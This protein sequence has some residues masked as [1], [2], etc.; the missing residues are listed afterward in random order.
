MKYS[1]HGEIV[2]NNTRLSGKYRRKIYKYKVKWQCKILVYKSKN[3]TKSVSNPSNE[4]SHLIPKLKKKQS[5]MH[6][7][8]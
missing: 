5:K 2:K 7:Y 3:E 8:K 1:F 4:A 6:N